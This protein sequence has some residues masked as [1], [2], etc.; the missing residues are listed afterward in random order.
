M[1]T[2]SGK[3]GKFD[4][5][6]RI[7]EHFPRRNYEDW[8]EEA[9][10]SLRGQPLESLTVATHEGIPVKPLY[11]TEDLPLTP[12]QIPEKSSRSWSTCCPVDLRRPEK[13]VLEA[14]RGL[15]Q[16]ADSLWLKVDRRISG[17]GRLNIG[18]LARLLEISREAPIYLDGRGAT[19][20]LAAVVAAASQ[21][22]GKASNF[23]GGFD[24]DPLGTLAADGVLKWSLESS[25]ELMAEMVS[26]TA[27]HTPKLSVIAVSSI[28]YSNGGA[29]AV[30]ELAFALATGVEYLRRLEMTNLAPELA[31]RS[32]R[33]IMPVGRD[34]FMG[35]AKLRALRS[36]WGQILGA[37]GV[38]GDESSPTIHAVTSPRCL[39]TRDPWVNMLRATNESFAAVVGGADLIT[40]L[41]FDS[42]IGQSD[43]HAFRLALNTSNVLREEAHLGA[44]S[45]PAAG[46]YFVENLTHELA[47]SAWKKFQ[48][49]ESSGGMVTYL[50]SG[51]VA[52][53]LSDG[54]AR[55]RQAVA[56]L[57][58]PITGVSSYPNL[59][60]EP[61]QRTT[62]KRSGRRSPDDESTAVHRI[63][64]DHPGS[65]PA[66]V[67]DA[68]G[69]VSVLELIELLP[70]DGVAEKIVSITMGR[71]SRPFE[72]LRDTADRQLATAGLRPRV[73]LA[74]MESPEKLRA[75]NSFAVN[76]L[77]SGGIAAVEGE[78]IDSPE[79]SAA[80][81][82][83]SGSRSAI[84]CVTRE[85]AD[86]DVPL[87]ASSLK[88]RGAQR[89]LVCLEPHDHQSA[90]R[91][92]GVDG[93]V[94]RGCN[95]QA[96][97]ADL[98]EV[99][100]MDHV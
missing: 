79:S 94:H 19:P 24:F 59:R 18:I 100:R 20:A 12:L 60:E 33:F 74:G 75:E 89:V 81:F 69:G 47:L 9:R 39:T 51:A 76:V 31:G 45:D 14:A 85:R 11:T 26:W 53:D 88:E 54:L 17:W 48:H 98:L 27:E 32:S 43:D 34:L 83:A 13:A 72:D 97:L 29:T 84:I 67:E 3:T 99:E 91:S 44:V 22:T 46:S 78:G 15:A 7:S 70:G 5:E 2:N 62:G 40:V 50:R 66:A 71:D 63:V 42:A 96:L 86:V 49:I 80:A 64:T 57:R 61:L 87:L 25:F 68:E 30:D 37:C 38:T 90:W 36:L 55:R 52:R 6:L 92:A 1:T 56:S 16:G 41:P 23:H 58:D 10:L 73:F 65:F 8:E 28:P 95:I 82:A 77:A 93:Y 4:D 35:I 21:R